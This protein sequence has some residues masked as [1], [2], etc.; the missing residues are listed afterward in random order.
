MLCPNCG[1]PLPDNAK[2][3]TGCGMALSAPPAPAYGVPD[4]GYAQP[5]PYAG[6]PPGY[7]DQPQPYAEQPPVYADQPQA[8]AEQ[9]PVYAEQPQA[10]SEPAP[11]AA[12]PVPAP[13]REVSARPEKTRNPLVPILAIVAFL[14]I[15][16]IVLILILDGGKSFRKGDE[17][18]DE[19]VSATERAET[20]TEPAPATTA[21]PPEPS[22]EPTEP[23]EEPTE[24]I[25]QP[26]VTE[27]PA[28]PA[29]SDKVAAGVVSNGVYSNEYLNICATAPSGWHIGTERELAELNELTLEKYQGTD[30]EAI[31][32]EN[33]QCFDLLMT[34]NS[35]GNNVNI[36]FQQM[37]AGFAMISDD[38]YFTVAEST[39]R[40]QL[41]AGGFTVEGYELVSLNFCGETKTF[42][43]LTS[44]LSGFRM[45]Q[46]QGIIRTAGEYYGIMTLSIFDSSEAQPFLDHFDTLRG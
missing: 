45:V 37:P 32:K 14:S 24:E 6:Q 4:P 44:E 12:E 41:T 22:E 28:P 7:A 34:D 31:L 40:E 17:E 1:K 27:P 19:K 26:P 36:L 10:Y 16:A 8:Y 20:T 18:G 5:Q 11:Q 15:A 9:P 30:I 29:S 13:A 21:A 43:K 33:G 39:Y 46:Y 38:T 25:T 23:S 2:F 42:L 3:C 35:S